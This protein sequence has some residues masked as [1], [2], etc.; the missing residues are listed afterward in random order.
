M[1]KYFLLLNI[2]ILISSCVSYKVKNLNE[3]IE[4]IEYQNIEFVN[5][6]DIYPS[7]K[8]VGNFNVVD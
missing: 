3:N 2:T 5:D 1:K 7:K 8:E 6:I 4:E